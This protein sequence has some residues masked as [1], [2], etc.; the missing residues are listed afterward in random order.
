M[1]YSRVKNIW[2]VANEFGFSVTSLEEKPR[3]ETMVHHEDLPI[4][5]NV[6]PREI[7]WGLEFQ[8]F[9]V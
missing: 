9:T 3:R 2:G 7:P 6:E 8:E 5:E 4:V 1:D